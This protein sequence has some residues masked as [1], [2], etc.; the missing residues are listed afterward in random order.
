MYDYSCLT[1]I[2]LF[3]I[4]S[5]VLGV[6]ISVGLYIVRPRMN[7]LDLQVGKEELEKAKPASRALSY[8]RFIEA[9]TK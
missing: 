4:T 1:Q 6:L 2:T 3:E 5:A 9:M 8:R 7:I